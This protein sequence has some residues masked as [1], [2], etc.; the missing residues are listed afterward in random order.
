MTFCFPNKG[1]CSL[2]VYTGS[3]HLVI[4]SEAKQ[5][6]VGGGDCH[7]C[8]GRLAMTR[9]RNDKRGEGGDCMIIRKLL[10]SSKEKF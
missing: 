9:E 3:I 2:V 6:L 1:A 10:I 4:V 5:S 8:H 7:V